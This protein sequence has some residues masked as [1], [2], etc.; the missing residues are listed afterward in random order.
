VI[1]VISLVC[2]LI[3]C[4]VF[5]VIIFCLRTKKK[6]GEEGEEGEEEDVVWTDKAESNFNEFYGRQV[7]GLEVID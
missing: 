4:T 2:V 5:A 7:E 6:A 1:I 3:V